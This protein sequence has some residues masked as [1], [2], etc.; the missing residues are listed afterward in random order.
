M[1][2]TVHY[3]FTVICVTTPHKRNIFAVYSDAMAKN[4]SRDNNIMTTTQIRGGT[5][6]IR[7]RMYRTY[8]IITHVAALRIM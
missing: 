3:K 5:T 8:K 7:A 6:V 2:I 1:H 4:K